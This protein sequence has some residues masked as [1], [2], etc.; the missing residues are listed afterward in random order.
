[1]QLVPVPRR[2][3]ASSDA[4]GIGRSTLWGDDFGANQG[5]IGEHRD[6][7]VA[8]GGEKRK[9]AV[10][11]PDELHGSI[12]DVVIAAALEVGI[13]AGEGSG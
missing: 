3:F 10:S 7:E 8:Q 9:A 5:G 1:M 13:V 2:A 11:L 6:Q 4:E 12:G